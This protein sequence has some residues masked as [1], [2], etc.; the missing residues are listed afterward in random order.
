LR[1]PVA[2]PAAVVVDHTA[3]P[4]NERAGTVL[5]N[6]AQSLTRLEVG[7]RVGDQQPPVLATG[8]VVDDVVGAAPGVVVVDP[9]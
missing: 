5:V 1:R 4:V 8:A 7:Q 2:Q 6:V 9:L 3:Q